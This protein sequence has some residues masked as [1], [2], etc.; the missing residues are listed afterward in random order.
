MSQLISSWP[1]DVGVIDISMV[2]FTLGPLHLKGN[3]VGVL[4]CLT[5]F[6]IKSYMDINSSEE[7]YLNKGVPITALRLG[8]VDAFSFAKLSQDAE[9][10]VIKLFSFRRYLTIRLRCIAD[11]SAELKM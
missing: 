6:R 11:P 7:K 10:Y 2:R 4:D 8:H 3:W 5:L 1:H 9:I